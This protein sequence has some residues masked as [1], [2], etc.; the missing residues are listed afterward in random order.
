[1][2]KTLSILGNRNDIDFFFVC[3]RHPHCYFFAE[4]VENRIEQGFCGKVDIIFN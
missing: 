2:H 1:M 4:M 3:S